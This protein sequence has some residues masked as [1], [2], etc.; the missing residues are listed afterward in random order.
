M[1][2]WVHAIWGKP[3]SL[4]ASPGLKVFW[5]SFSLSSTALTGM[6]AVDT[7]EGLFNGCPQAV[8]LSPV[9]DQIDSLPACCLPSGKDLSF[10]YYYWMLLIG[11]R[12]RRNGFKQRAVF[13]S[14]DIQYVFSNCFKGILFSSTFW[15]PIYHFKQRVEVQLNTQANYCTKLVSVLKFMKLSIS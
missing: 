3:L 14:F 7:G 1:T 13:L 5:G 4:S 15:K 11:K 6:L 2:S 9:G 12:L 8:E 10:P